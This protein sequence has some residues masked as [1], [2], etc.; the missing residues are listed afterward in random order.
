MVD[1]ARAAWSTSRA[2]QGRP[3]APPRR[4]T[5]C[6]HRGQTARSS[7]VS[8]PHWPPGYRPV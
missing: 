3:R 2:P 8:A 7:Q 5:D 1:L 4:R 6:L